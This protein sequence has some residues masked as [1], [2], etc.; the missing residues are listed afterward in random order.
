Q[1]YLLFVLNKI[2]DIQKPCHTPILFC[3]PELLSR[4][5]DGIS[6]PLGVICFVCLIAPAIP[7][8]A[9]SARKQL[10][11]WPRGARFDY[12]VLLVGFSGMFSLTRGEQVYLPST[13]GER[14]CVLAFD[15]EQDQFG[16]ITKIESHTTT[17][18]TAIF[19]Y[20]VPDKI[21][22]VGEAPRLHH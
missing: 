19:S 10:E 13:R 11:E 18:R 9:R 14:A 4:A 3:H 21:R 8:N 20:F 6:R 12:C 16:H 5:S 1:A 2:C 7:A 17:V 15:P 22:F